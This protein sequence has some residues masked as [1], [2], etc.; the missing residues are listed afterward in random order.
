M[1]DR[2]AGFEEMD[3]VARKLVDQ[4][5]ETDG[6]MPIPDRHA[7]YRHELRQYQL[8]GGAAALIAAAL[9]IGLEAEPAWVGWLV[10]A[11]GLITLFLGRPKPPVNRSR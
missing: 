8:V 9:L 5:L 10:G 6:Q 3:T 7:M 2:P 1:G 11:A 4:A